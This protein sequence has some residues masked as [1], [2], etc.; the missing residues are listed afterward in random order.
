MEA[1]LKRNNVAVFSS[2]YTLYG[3]MSDR[4]MKTI[5]AFVPRLEIYSID[6]AFLDLHDMPYANLLELGVKIRQAVQRN[7]GIPVTIGI[8]ATKTLAKMANRYAKKLHRQTGVFW[9]ANK[10]LEQEML[11]FTAVADI[12]GIG[13]QYA[14]LLNRNGVKTAADLADAP[15]DW[16]RGK[17]S[18]VGLRLL[19]EIRGI[20]SIQW[21]FETPSKKNICTSRS[22]GKLLTDKA[23]IAEALV[24]YVAS[25]ALK[26]RKQKSSCKTI[27]VFLQ[28]NP[29]KTEEAQ[30]MRSINIELETASNNTS[31]LIKYALRGLDITFQPGYR[32]M[33]AGIIVMDLVPED[34]VQASM[35]DGADRTKN[36]MIMSAIDK[37]NQALGKE[38]VR[39]AVQG[40][41]KSY[42]L[43]TE[44]L[45]PRYTTN[46]KHILKV[47]I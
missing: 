28:T 10:K 23:A 20:P 34:K 37:V 3:D 12:W 30:Y 9:A 43:K 19:N 11:S 33:K 39:V 4:V 15:D 45:S 24:N 42:R 26:L 38:I 16:I 17:M 25:C 40:F 22:F 5:A 41:E 6:E 35:F 47:R 18:V 8:G 31:E 36:K 46:F 1:L 21:E 13:H 29:H 44:Y 2:N 14:L 32:Y 7:T 27:Q